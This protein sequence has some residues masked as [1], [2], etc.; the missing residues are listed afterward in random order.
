[1]TG[2][3]THRRVA[4]IQAPAVA[5]NAA[6]GL[7]PLREYARQAAAAQ[8]E[9]VL[10]PEAYLGG[11][12]RG[13]DFDT[14]VGRR[15]PEGREW[16][17][18]YHAGAV[19]IPGPVT[20]ELEQIAA[21]H[22]IH[23]VCGVIERAGSTLFCTVVF[24][25]PDRGIVSTRRKLMP[26]GSERLIW[27]QGDLEQSPVVNTPIGAVGAVICWENYMPLLRTFA[28]SKGVQIWCAPTADARETWEVTMRHIAVEGRCFVL[29]AN[30]YSLRSDYPDDYPLDVPADTVLCEGASMIVDPS[31][32]VLA[33]PHR[34][35]PTMLVAELDLDDIVRSAFDF[36][37]VGHYSRSDLFTLQVRT[38]SDRLV[39][40]S[41]AQWPYAPAAAPADVEPVEQP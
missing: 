41:V 22:Q 29:S 19:D 10:F 25:D 23:I 21:E 28:Y 33:G 26:T 15:T 13:L 27:G 20:T 11:Y 35:G 3:S 17:R 39:Q 14:T 38:G 9:L 6:A 31:G 2:A 7:E 36:D 24:V 30:Q 34:S 8:C 18:R 32:T 37:P 16:F 12:P 1:V 40:E 5:F 4:V